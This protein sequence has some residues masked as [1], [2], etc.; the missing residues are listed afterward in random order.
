MTEINEESLNVYYNGLEHLIR[1][2][3]GF[4]HSL[5]AFKVGIDELRQS[6][7]HKCLFELRQ[8]REDFDILTKCLEQSGIKVPD[9]Y[10]EKLYRVKPLLDSPEWPVAMNP[11]SIVETTAA[12]K[13]RANH[14]L[15]L[16]VIEILEGLKFLDYGCGEGYIVAEA[17]NRQVASV[18]GYD[19]ERQWEDNPCLT[20]DFQAV[21]DG[22]PY[23]VVL[24]YDVLDH[25]KN[26]VE[27]L[28]KIR[29]LL[30]PRGRIYL[31]MHPWCSKHGGHLYKTINKAYA[32]ILFNEAEQLKLFG[33]TSPFVHKLT[34]PIITYREW[35]LHA[36]FN[37]VQESIIRDPE[38][39]PFFANME[40]VHVKE[41]IST[42]WKGDNPDK[43]LTLNFVNYILEPMPLHKQVI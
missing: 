37:I 22:A 31:R 29:D 27:D 11:D 38:L 35:F 2:V 42:P 26:P 18:V 41:R 7:E 13:L 34:K 24:L 39:D 4:T 15:D 9:M 8:L 28:I 5:R 10:S 21:I 43:A 32:H 30:S 20:N 14:I 1:Q 25:C 40:N 3:E 23:D 17:A 19:I 12:K 33:A 6:K 36:G 16:I